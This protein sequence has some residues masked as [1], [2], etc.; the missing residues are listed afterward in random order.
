ML[1]IMEHQV[2]WFAQVNAHEHRPVHHSVDHLPCR[3]EDDRFS[4]DFVHCVDA[5]PVR[6]GLAATDRVKC[7]CKGMTG[8]QAR[9]VRSTGTDAQ[10]SV[11]KTNGTVERV[12]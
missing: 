12:S 3:V 10:V 1:S 9:Q 6:S 8:P 11:I 5:R 7:V 4:F 2:R